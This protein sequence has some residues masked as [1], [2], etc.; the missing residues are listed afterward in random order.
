MCRSGTGSSC[1]KV[2]PWR[3]NLRDYSLGDYHLV[4]GILRATNRFRESVTRDGQL[5]LRNAVV[6]FG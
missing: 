1:C 3:A 6:G 4:W 2:Q 5:S